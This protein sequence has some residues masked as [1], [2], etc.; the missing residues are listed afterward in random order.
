M[1]DGVYRAVD[2]RRPVLLVALDISAAFDTINH[3]VLLQR[4]ECDFGVSGTAVCWLRSYLDDR[5]QFV[6]LGRLSSSTSPCT[7][8]V[9]Q[10]SVLGPLLFTAYM[11]PIGDV[12]ESFGVSYHQFAHDTQLYVEMDASNTTAALN[13]LSD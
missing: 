2:D 11:A 1:L 9:L 10:G 6:K 12:I 5:Q 3:E 8:G 4:M 13:R 7:T